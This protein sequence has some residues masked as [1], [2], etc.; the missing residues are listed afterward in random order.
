M[1]LSVKKVLVSLFFL[2][3]PASSWADLYLYK[4]S[5]GR[6]YMT[7]KVKSGQFKLLKKEKTY[8]KPFARFLR[9][10]RRFSYIIQRMA[11]QLKLEPALLHAIIHIES[12]Y[13]PK[14][15]SPK[16]AVGLMQLMPSTAKRYGVN[17]RMDPEANVR[18]GARYVKDLL[19]R[20]ENNLT[21]VLAAYN[22]GE[23]TVK[24]YGNKVP[25]YPETQS[26]VKK[27]LK[28][29]RRTARKKLN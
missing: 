9:N 15:I 14:A 24:K 12:S 20:Y 18:G 7:D 3:I 16:G 2:V 8:T 13:N 17:N 1:N 10:K 25:P 22:A 28:S 23:H 4:D 6:I 29:Y 27:V 26:Y 5:A 11:K 19:K 21:L